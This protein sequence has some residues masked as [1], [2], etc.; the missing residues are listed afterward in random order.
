[1]TTKVPESMLDAGDLFAVVVPLGGCIPFFGTT[2]P[3]AAWLFPFGQAVSRT[4]YAAL[5]ALLG[6]T[7]GVGD[8]STTF[9]LPD[10]R[11]RVAV[12]RDNLGGTPANRITGGVSGV[13]GE[14]L[15]AVGGSQSLQQHTHA[16]TDPG[17]SHTGV[18]Q[19]SGTNVN[20]GGL[21]QATEGTATGS[22][23]TGITISNAGSGNSQ[24]V[25][26]SIIANVLMRV[27]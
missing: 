12:G 21:E 3:N 17:H 27:L 24:N 11:G 8:G 23:T 26:P 6:T 20:G 4:T 5:F 7:H 18:V 15:G 22:S 9:N 13:E 19:K 16:I 2:P 10:V 14:T 1:M 25:Q